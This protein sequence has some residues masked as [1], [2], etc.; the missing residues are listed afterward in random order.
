MCHHKVTP[1]KQHRRSVGS[2][3][4]DSLSSLIAT[5][6]ATTPHYVRCIKVFVSTILQNDIVQ[7]LRFS[8]M[9]KKSLS[10][11]TPRK[12]SNS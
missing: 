5:L 3:F 1:S 11:G 12:L 9:M 7:T 10:N 2:Q 8:Q 4:R 6:H